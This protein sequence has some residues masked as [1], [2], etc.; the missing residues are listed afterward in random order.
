MKLIDQLAFYGAYHH[1]PINQLIH[2]IFVPTIIWSILVWFATLHPIISL[3]ATLVY[4]I[5]YIYIDPI[6]GSLWA[7]TVGA[8]LAWSASS[9]AAQTHVFGSYSPAFI[10]LLI[11]VFSWYMQIHPGHAIF[12]KRKPALMESL[13]QAFALAPL[14]V[15]YEL[16]FV[17]GY[18]PELR[19][20]LNARYEK[21]IQEYKAKRRQ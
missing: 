2:F 4:S 8:P 16:L 14:F 5:F 7:L 18:R 12:E 1:N 6:A 10:A 15:F 13:S 19:K 20:E 3:I 11:N 17:L 21:D 9:F